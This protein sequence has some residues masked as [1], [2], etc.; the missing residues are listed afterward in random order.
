MN[1][2]KTTI[3]RNPL[4]L[5]LSCW[6]PARLLLAW[7]VLIL[8]YVALPQ[9]DKPAATAPQ[10]VR[11]AAKE[12][13]IV[14]R[15]TTP[16]ELE[17]LLGKPQNEDRGRDGDWVTLTQDYGEVNALF[18]RLGEFTNPFTLFKLRA[19]GE[20]L[21]IGQGKQLNLRTVGD[22]RKLDSFW[23]LAGVS[24]AKLDLRDQASK[25]SALTFDSLTVWPPGDQLPAGFNPRTLLE[26]G[27]NPG[28]GV[29]KL[30]EKGIDGRGVGIAILDQPLLKDHEEFRDKITRYEAVEVDGV[31]PQMHGAAVV[32][33]AV[34]KSCGVAPGA[35]VY[36][37]AAPSWKWLRNE[38]WAEQ[39][40]RIVD[41]NS[42]IHDTP[43][44]RVVSISLGAFSERPNYARWRQALQ[45]AE[46]AN[47]LVV[48]CDPD[49]LHIGT[50]RRIENH[51]EPQPGDYQRGLY[52]RPDA[53]LLVPAANRTLASFRGCQVYTYD[54]TGGMSWTVP[55]LAG[56]AALAW[57]VDPNL[58]PH[59]IV[60]LWSRTAAK[61]AVGP[62]LDPIAVITAIEH[63]SK[64]SLS[65]R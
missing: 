35:S 19:A 52:G 42:Q 8:P 5:I 64:V 63:D 38:P 62:V 29:R 27:K 56:V 50:L 11:T 16:D 61:T 34:G 57:Q 1:F 22:L 4:C 40:E 46:Q 32:S 18:A 41:L 65:T 51:D 60:E 20:E 17:R 24:V 13:A 10:L 26:Q 53:V 45:K 14:A 25:L 43:K 44:I 6:P 36:Y 59:Q 15:L 2:K 21:D 39:L 28:L 33:I 47:I 37:F 48:T 31:E 30:H 23:G 9:A 12:G 49:F 55:Y 58:T 3:P 54:R 7:A